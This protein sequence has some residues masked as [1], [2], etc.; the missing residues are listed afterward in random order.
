MPQENRNPRRFAD[1]PLS[2][3]YPTWVK[4][5]PADH[6]TRHRATYT[7]TRALMSV[8]DRITDAAASAAYCHGASRAPDDALDY[9]GETYGGLARSIRDSALSYRNYLSRP[10]P[11]G[12]WNRFGTDA[13][14]LGELAHLGYPNAQIVSWRDLVDAGAAAGNV[15]F[16]GLTTFFFVAIFQPAPFMSLGSHWGAGDAH[17]GAGDGFWGGI[18]QSAGFI[19]EIRRVIA[20]CKPAHTSCRHVVVFLDSTSGLNAQLLPTGNY[21]VYPCNE[22]WE[23]IRPS[24]AYNPFYITS[25]LVP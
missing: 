3:A 1:L 18:N 9:L 17:W 25:P 5:E 2:A 7:F 13:G 4:P 10:G 14:L 21:N 12:R 16:G 11:V 20:Q 15:V 22:Q 19:T 24:Y 8:W 23:R 6:P